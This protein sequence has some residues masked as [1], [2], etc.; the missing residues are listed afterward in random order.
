MSKIQPVVKTPSA[1]RNRTTYSPYEKTVIVQKCSE[2]AASPKKKKKKKKREKGRRQLLCN[3]VW[4]SGRMHIEERSTIERRAV[5][6]VK[7]KK[8]E[9]ETK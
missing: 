5:A 6:S 2:K 4:L 7:E 8:D 3:C 1:R 9:N